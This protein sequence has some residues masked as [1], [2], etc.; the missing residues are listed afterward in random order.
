MLCIQYAV[1]THPGRVRPNNEDNFWVGGFYRSDVSKGELTRLGRA[2][3]SRF[4]AAVCDGMGG[5]AAGETASLLTVESLLPHG[6][7]EL[8]DAAERDIQTANRRICRFIEE[9]GGQRSGSTVAA[10]YMD[11]GKAV[12]CNVGDSRVYRFRAGCLTQL[13]RDHSKAQRLIDMGFLSPEEA[14]NSTSRYELTQYLG[15]FEDEMTVEPWFSQPEALLS[16][17]CFLLCSDGLT[18]ML[19]DEEIAHILSSGNVRH[20]ASQLIAEALRSG[21]RDNITV[22]VLQVNISPNHP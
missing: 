16:G 15:I 2:K 20:Q 1:A 22:V 17:D 3:P 6:L 21:G 7:Y 14:R 5:A 12:A 18:D 8:P 13:S 10:L 9:H 4:L 19:W 11:S